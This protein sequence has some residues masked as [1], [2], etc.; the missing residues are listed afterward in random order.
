M[1]M[2]RTKIAPTVN[3]SSAFCLLSF[4]LILISTLATAQQLDSEEEG[5]FRFRFV[6]PKAG[7]RVSAIAG[8]P[9]DAST[10]YAG[11][12]SGGVWKSTDGGNVWKPIFDKQPAAAI[13]SIAVAPSD[14][15]SVWA[16]TGEAWAIR[17]SDVMGNGVYLSTDS[18]KSWNHVGLDET[19]RI[20]RIL[21]HPTNP[22]IAF[23][24]ALG[25]A[26]GPQQERGVYRTADR[27]QH[28]RSEEHTSELQSR[29]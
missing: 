23:V 15:S 18:G 7:N 14:P 21:I 12:A 29:Q 25:R 16:G 8:I 28:W 27:G 11:A 4:C 22:D 17:D 13:G 3:I 2:P 5:Q 1:R 24:C 9:G 26:T 19:G 6:G 10:Y 20:G